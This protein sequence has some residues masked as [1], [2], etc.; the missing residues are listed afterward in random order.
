VPNSVLWLLDASAETKNR[1]GLYA[2]KKG[3]ERSRLIFAPR[4][5][6]AN[7]LARYPLAD[8]FLDTSPYGAHTTASD[9]LW[10]GVPVLTISGRNFA[11][12][13]CGSL[14]RSAGLPE[15]VMSSGR[16]Y[17]EAAVTLGNHPGR[18]DLLKVKLR[19]K[20]DRCTLF[21][22]DKLVGKLE[23]LYREM[24]ADYRKGNLP[25]PDLRNLEIYFEA[26]IEHDHEKQE[27]LSVEDYEGHYRQALA[28][29]HWAR[30]IAADDR[31]WTKAAIAEAEGSARKK[32]ASKSSDSE[33]PIKRR[34]TG[35]RG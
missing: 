31:L 32:T 30:P 16:D 29:R 11:S 34:K 2:E 10:M 9:A 18:V 24:I 5:K 4:V 3:V 8:L 15:L 33:A 28:R 7:H 17:V 23:E 35:T 14:V 26:G 13:V 25:R 22:T 6:N 20:R 12:R 19:S 27:M 21:D 1:L